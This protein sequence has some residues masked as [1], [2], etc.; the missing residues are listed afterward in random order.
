MIRFE[1]GLLGWIGNDMYINN[2]KEKQVLKID[3]FFPGSAGQ[4]PLLMIKIDGGLLGW[5]GN[6]VHIKNI[7]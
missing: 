4:S 3:L 6:Y 1:C 7:K 2:V 5:I